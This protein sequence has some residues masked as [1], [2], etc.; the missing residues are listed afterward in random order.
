MCSDSPPGHLFPKAD[1]ALVKAYFF[2]RSNVFNDWERWNFIGII[3][4]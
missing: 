1:D 3:L 2:V 4:G